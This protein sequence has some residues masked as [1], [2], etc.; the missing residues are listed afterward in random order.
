MLDSQMG[1]LSWRA[2]LSFPLLS[3]GN[4]NVES[5]IGKAD[6]G[7][8]SRF[9][10]VGGSPFPLPPPPW[11]EEGCH[12]V[13]LSQR[14]RIARRASSAPRDPPTGLLFCDDP[15]TTT[16]SWKY[17]CRHLPSNLRLKLGSESGRWFEIEVFRPPR[18]RSSHPPL[19]NTLT[20]LTQTSTHVRLRLKIS[21]EMLRLNCNLFG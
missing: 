20:Q 21:P 7:E 15:P 9:Q 4:S 5:W 18:L 19:A 6:S 17:F 11:L 14:A 12:A 8:V 1:K 2:Q 3:V 13:G 16:L 10:K